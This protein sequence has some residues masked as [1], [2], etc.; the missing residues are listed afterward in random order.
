MNKTIC[1]IGARGGIGSA[2]CERL[3][4]DIDT[5]VIG[6]DRDGPIPINVADPA[7]IDRAF[8]AARA[9]HPVLDALVISSGIL[10]LGKLRSLDLDTWNKVLAINLT[11]PF[12]CCRAA[13]SWLRD[14]GRIVMVGSL[15]GRTGGVLTGT[16]YAVS[17]GGLESLTK[18]IAQELAPRGITVNCVAPGGVDTP[19]IAGNPPEAIASMKAA[20]PLKRLAQ[21]EEIAAGIGYLLSDDAAYITGSV[22]AIN[23]GLRMD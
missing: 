7:S 23:G 16:A 20:V 21:A 12:L 5:A 11:G 9:A 15:A 4:K 3:E 18:S 19:M 22:L 8:A 1:V 14:G 10:D 13:Q 2:L 17:K 6:M